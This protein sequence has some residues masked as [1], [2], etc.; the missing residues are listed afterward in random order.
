MAHWPW[1]TN[2]C[3]L[4]L[5]R[6]AHMHLELSVSKV[7]STLIIALFCISPFSSCGWKMYDVLCITKAMFCFSFFWTFVQMVL[8][9]FPLASSRWMIFFEVGLAIICSNQYRY[10]S[11]V[12]ASSGQ[13]CS[14]NMRKGAWLKCGATEFHFLKNHITW[15]CWLYAF[16]HQARQS[17]GR[18]LKRPKRLNMR[19]EAGFVYN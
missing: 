1:T 18:F 19:Q 6:C 14:S 7:Y 17:W 15:S 9:P 8:L 16:L 11:S 2:S 10:C 4:F 12:S 13:C 3:T 5:L